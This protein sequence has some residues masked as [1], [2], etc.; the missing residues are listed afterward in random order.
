M[1]T[2]AC[3]LDDYAR[4]WDIDQTPVISS[5]ATATSALGGVSD[6]R[7]RRTVFISHT[8]AIERDDAELWLAALD[9]MMTVPSGASLEMFQTVTIN[10][11]ST[12][13]ETHARIQRAIQQI[14]AV[15]V[16]SFNQVG[17]HL[18]GDQ[19]DQDR[20]TTVTE[21]ETYAVDI[22][23][24]RGQRALRATEELANWLGTTAVRAADLLGY[25][26]SYY[27]WLKGVHP[28]LA[29]TLNLFEAHSFVAALVD[30]VGE[31]RAYTWLQQDEDG[32]KRIELLRARKDRD[33]LYRLS[34]DLLFPKRQEVH[35]E[36]DY[37]LEHDPGSAES[38]GLFG[39]LIEVK[40]L[41]D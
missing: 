23:T 7:R 30:A 25:K 4:D 34:N 20:H 12:L 6:R 22:S 32:R 18:S 21:L 40:E 16:D 37:D 17:P 14:A 11:T 26:R 36:P 5:A 35:W 28:Y 10:W 31:R 9:I 13:R 29:T 39:E 24:S 2:A 33:R 8:A 19:L 27:N 41:S 38:E 3:V 1:T 15:P